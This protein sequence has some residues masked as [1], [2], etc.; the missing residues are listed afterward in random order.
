MVQKPTNEVQSKQTTGQAPTY[1]FGT[2]VEA[3][4]D[5]TIS[6]V[7]EALKAEG[8]GVLTT[9]D[10][11]ETM[12]EKL[13][14]DFE[15][16]VILGACNPQLAH[17]ALELEHSVGL[18]LPC[19]VVVHEAHE[20]DRTACTQVDIADPVAMLGIIQNP[21]MQELATEARTRLKRVVAALTASR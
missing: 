16:Y 6:Q 5:E 1:S 7:R 8:F 10:V 17:R 15:R 9:I 12:K 2:S 13:H 3:T 11:K 19:N 18:L 14:V 21:A 4:F 20:G